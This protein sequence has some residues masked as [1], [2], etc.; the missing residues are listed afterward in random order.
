MPTLGRETAQ[1]FYTRMSNATINFPAEIWGNVFILSFQTDPR[2]RENLMCVNRRFS[3]IACETPRLW[4]CLSFGRRDQSI[5]LE[6]ARASLRR[7]G[8]LPPDV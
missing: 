5:E 1:K 2:T 3:S 7:A 4:T 6:H 8:N